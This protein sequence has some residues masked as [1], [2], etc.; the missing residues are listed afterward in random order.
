MSFQAI[1]RAVKVIKSAFKKLPVETLQKLGCSLTKG[2]DKAIVRAN[3]DDSEALVHK[4]PGWREISSAGLGSPVLQ[5]ARMPAATTSP[6]PPPFL[7]IS[8]PRP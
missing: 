8:P 3:D 5:Q 2:G 1:D 4:S 6:A 7:D